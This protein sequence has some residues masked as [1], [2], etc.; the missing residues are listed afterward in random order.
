VRNVNLKASG[1]AKETNTTDKYPTKYTK[2]HFKNVKFSKFSKSCQIEIIY[3]LTK[4][5]RFG[6]STLIKSKMKISPKQQNA[7]TAATTHDNNNNYLHQSN[8]NINIKVIFV[9]HLFLG[10]FKYPQS[11]TQSS[12]LKLNNNIITFFSYLWNSGLVKILRSGDIETNPGPVRGPNTGFT[13]STKITVMTYNIRGLKDKL[14]LKRVLNKCSRALSECADTFILLQETHLDRV[15]NERIKFLWRQGYGTS[16]AIGRQG[17]TLSLFSNTWELIKTINDENGRLCLTVVQKNG[18]RLGLCN[19]YA[20]ND[21]DIDFFTMVY[22]RLF[23]IKNE[24]P[25]IDLVMGGDFNLVLGQGDSQNRSSNNAERRSRKFIQEQNNLLNLRDSYRINNKSG[26]FTWS[27][28]SCM[29][30]LDLILIEKDLASLE[31]NTKLE[32]GFDISDHAMLIT[33]FRVKSILQKGK[34]LIKINASVLENQHSLNEVKNELKFQLSHIPNNWNPH[35]KLDF[36]KMTIRSVIS[37]IAGRQVKRDE[38]EQEAI[39]NQL[40]ILRNSKESLVNGGLH[41]NQQITDID[42]AISQ[43]E[44]ELKV[45]LD[46][47]AK[48]LILRSGA[49]WYEEGEKNNAYFLNIINKRQQQTL[50]A[51]IDSPH[52]T[53]TSQNDIMDHIVGFYENLYSHK[54]TDDNFDE[55]LSDL[56]RLSEEDR[57]KL[58]EPISLAELEVTLK[59]CEE[60]APG[61]DGIPYL[62]YKKLWP[63]IGQYLLDAWN[64]SSQEG[65]L[66]EDQRVS[67]ITLLPKQ[68]KDLNKIENWRPITLSNCDLKIFTKLIANRVSKVLDKIISPNQTAY[69]PGRVV[70]DNLRVFDFYNNYCR[71][72]NIEGLLVSLD[73]KKAFDSVSH[74]Y[75][76]EVL[77]RYGFSDSFIST[78]KLL[79]N[80]IKANILVNGYK[81]VMIKIARSVKQG[82]ALSCALFILC[83]DPLIRKLESNPE[84]ESIDIPRSEY[85]NVPI[86]GKVGGFADDIGLAVK[87]SPGTVEAI[88]KDYA[89]FTRLSGIELNIAKTEILKMNVNSFNAAFRPQPM[90]IN[91]VVINTSEQIKI[92]GIVFS[93]DTSKAYNSNIKE[94]IIKLE[95]QLVR[96]LPRCLSTE[97]KILIVKTFGLSQLINSL[98]MCEIQDDE[99]KEI[100]S[101]IFKFLWNKKWVGNQA[102]DRIKRDI[103]K[104][105]HMNG[106]LN[107]PDIKS[108]NL[109]LKTRQ[110]IRAMNSNHQINLVQKYVLENLGYYEYYKLEYVKICVT[111]PVVKGYQITTNLITDRIRVPLHEDSDKYQIRTNIIASTDIIEY[112]RRKKVP[113]VIYRFRALADQ[114]IENLHE[115]INEFR[116]PRH[117]RLRD[118]AR[119]VLSFFPNDWIQAVTS[120]DDL[121]SSITYDTTF[122][123][124]NLQLIDH[125]FVTVKKIRSLIQSLQTNQVKPYL[126]ANKFELDDFNSDDHNPYLLLRKALHTPR[127]RFFKYRI[128][129]GDIFCNS[130]MYKF[131]MSDT[132]N[133]PTCTNTI[134]SIKHVLWSCPRAERIWEFVR[135]QT[136]AYIGNDYL[137]YNTIVLGN[138]NPNLAM[139][140]IITLVTRSILSIN[141]EDFIVNDVINEKINNL[142][143]YEKKCFGVNSKKMR[144]RW[145]NL[146]NKYLNL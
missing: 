102:P 31:V 121:D 40:N 83:I 4:N 27:R 93:N 79:Y 77:R 120:G 95:K 17:G 81:S 52:G 69:I 116:Y 43:L 38:S 54:E 22:D 85:S 109:A 66:T 136:S 132:P 19:I 55:L 87:N 8:F 103:L 131:H 70:H 117:D 29:S 42:N 71:T 59:G 114:G 146:I 62:V 107:V 137:S 48:S 80:D 89:I 25:D 112:F 10:N 46:T 78:V 12:Y 133:C 53:L 37:V 50:I 15:E 39:C 16:P 92:C 128:L 35:Q 106:G 67:C 94:K 1:S 24:Y 63:E 7:I 124:N 41:S 74:K 73:A 145:G 142:F 90:R 91:G 56:P 30:R 11:K 98:Q 111:D 115:L 123:D 45:I 129:Q 134:E 138:P 58:D 18:R 76:H 108:L 99:I 82:D 6:D 14:K 60:S 86:K 96:W 23:E 49:K 65:S 36:L 47:K 104:M 139:E 127:D 2:L 125:N 84:I 144:A 64:Y 34:G 119:E 21:H 122:P 51:K 126:N 72:H 100:E 44:S 20:P 3:L 101:K 33:T 97:G 68:G 5:E 75:M 140:T 32:W 141:R 28:G 105:S 130:R 110:F 9:T 57:K 135:T 118:C 13:P 26:G 143:Y 88:F 61:P 113:L